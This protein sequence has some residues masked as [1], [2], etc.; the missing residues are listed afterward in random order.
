M[1][2]FSTILWEKKW[3]ATWM[4]KNILTRNSRMSWQKGICNFLCYVAMLYFSLSFSSTPLN[5]KSIIFIWSDRC[6][7]VRIPPPLPPLK[8]WLKWTENGQYKVLLVFWKIQSFFLELVLND[9][10]CYWLCACTI[11]MSGSIL[12]LELW[13]KMFLAI[14][15]AGLSTWSLKMHIWI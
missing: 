3:S 4:A 9:S 5:R 8:S 2:C 14:Q 12:V 15:V 13:A 11:P 6:L 1:N 10:S 7:S